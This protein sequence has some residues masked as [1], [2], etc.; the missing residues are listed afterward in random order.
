MSGG[1]SASP[2]PSPPDS[3]RLSTLHSSILLPTRV[4]ILH[5]SRPQLHQVVFFLKRPPHISISRHPTLDKAEYSTVLTLT[6]YSHLCV[7]RLRSLHP[8]HRLL[9]TEPS[10]ISISRVRNPDHLTYLHF[11]LQPCCANRITS[12]TAAVLFSGLRPE[13]ILENPEPVPSKRFIHREEQCRKL[14]HPRQTR[15]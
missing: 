13:Y 15:L 9:Q 8:S 14:Q 6:S 5:V 1:Q 10:H 12:Y 3:T 7:V 2:R 11:R 4:S